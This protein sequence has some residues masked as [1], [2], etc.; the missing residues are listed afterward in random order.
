MVSSPQRLREDDAHRKGMAF[1]LASFLHERRVPEETAVTILDRLCPRPH[2][3]QCTIYDP[4]PTTHDPPSSERSER[5]ILD[6]LFSFH[7]ALS[8]VP[9]L[10]PALGLSFLGERRRDRQEEGMVTGYWSP[11]IGCWIVYTG[12]LGTASD[13]CL[14]VRV[15]ESSS[16][17]FLPSSTHRHPDRVAPPRPPHAPPPGLRLPGSPFPRFTVSPTNDPLR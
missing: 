3:S 5:T 2:D 8:P 9:P 17:R 4:R 14:V 13:Q 12:R 11:V 16:H 6:S 1:G 15:H 10:R 7:F